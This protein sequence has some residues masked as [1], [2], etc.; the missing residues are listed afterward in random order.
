MV[1][2]KTKKKADQLSSL[3]LNAGELT[4]PVDSQDDRLNIQTGSYLHMECELSPFLL[5]DVI[6]FIFGKF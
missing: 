6:I 1:F 3:G 2:C 5:R 4:L